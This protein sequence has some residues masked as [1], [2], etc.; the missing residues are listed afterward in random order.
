M[1]FD[2][3]T[4]VCIVSPLTAAIGSQL[5]VNNTCLRWFAAQVTH[6]TRLQKQLPDARTHARTQAETNAA[7]PARS[8]PRPRR[9]SRL[10]QPFPWPSE[11]LSVVGFHWPVSCSGAV[12]EFTRR[13]V[14][15]CSG[16]YTKAYFVFGVGVASASQAPP[17]E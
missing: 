4:H 15:F 6:T 12:S 13:F 9:P 11:P 5:H 2:V 14:I 8:R 1:S 17:D 16:Y 7:L 10:R 3:T